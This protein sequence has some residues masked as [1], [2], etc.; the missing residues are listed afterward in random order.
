MAAT[1][2][3]TTLETGWSFKR[4]DQGDD[5]WAPVAKVPTVVHMDLLDNDKIPDPFLGTNEL[6]VEWVGEY[7]W[8]YQTT[9]DAVD[10]PDG[11]SAYLLPDGLDTFA[12]VRLNDVTIL[13]SENM[14]FSHRV[15]VTESL[16]SPGTNTLVI[17]F[18]SALIRGRELEDKHLEHRIAHNGE[19]GRLGV[20]WDCG[21]VLMTT[22]PF[23]PVRLEVSFA[24][25]KFVKVDYDVSDDL[26]TVTGT[27]SIDIK[28][29][30]EKAVFTLRYRDDQEIFSATAPVAS[31]GSTIVKFQLDQ[32]KLWVNQDKDR[33]WLELTIEGNQIMTRVWGGG[34][35]EDDVFYDTCDEL[36][37]LVWQDFMFACGSYPAWPEL[38]ESIHEEAKQNVRRLRHHPSVVI[39]AGNN[40]DYQIQEESNLEYNYEDKDTEAWLA[41]SF[42]ARYYYEHLLPAVVKEEAPAVPFWP[43]S[44]FSNGQNIYDMAVGDIHQWNVW[45]G[46]QEKYQRFD[47]IGGRFNS[48]FG[49][50]AFPVLATIHG[51]ITK[52]EDLYPQS[53]VLDFHNKADGHERRIATY[54][55]ENFQIAP[56]LASWTYLTQ[57]SQSEALLYAYRGWR[58]QWGDE[59][60]CGGALVWQLNDCWPATSWAIVDYFLRK[61]PAFYAIKRSLRPIAVGVQRDHHDWSVCH[62]RPAKTSSYNMWIASNS[63]EEV[64]VDTELRFVSIE[65]GEDIRPAVAK[66][67]VT[68]AANGTTIVVSGEINNVIDE[69][70]VLTAQIL[71][72]G[73]TISRNVD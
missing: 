50:A 60:R 25:V 6:D 49:L 29:P 65:S 35:Y 18:D 45:H 51:F 69:P 22:G 30:A 46:T 10:V 48:E 14:F 36:G 9:F 53:R 23:R 43:G 66:S 1:A 52:P 63:P 40:E 47:K 4:T 3:R 61:K 44:P 42:P 58:R 54:I 39:W 67:N 13:T 64:K 59:R 5:T 62:A 33:S 37:I 71:Q 70:H 7:S 55:S 32:A 56:D 12:H 21:T 16:R 73:I 11:A 19:T 26:Q 28:G 8:T 38:R 31:K 20:R 41:G 72:G 34:I 2:S 27:A 57:L 15:D 68:V 24:Y 17:D